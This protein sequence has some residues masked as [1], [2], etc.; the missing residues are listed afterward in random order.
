MAEELKR[1]ED[2]I[3]EIDPKVEEQALKQLESNK[4][5]AEELLKNPKKLEEFLERLEAKLSLIP[6]AGKYLSDIPMLI[7]LVK[8]Y[9]E[10]EYTLIPIGSIIAVIG[11]L[12]YFLSPVDAIPDLIP[13]V[14]YIDDA[15]VIG[16]VYALVHHD[17][18]EYK[19]WRDEKRK[20]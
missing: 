3:E 15:L 20:L 14:G 4:E 10:K 19:A 12:I 2:S 7:S 18:L 13:G 16:A 6:V 5:E 17:I 1:V 11:A 8:A 9:V